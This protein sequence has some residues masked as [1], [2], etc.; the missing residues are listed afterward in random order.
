MNK[1]EPTGAASNVGPTTCAVLNH[2][3]GMSNVVLN[4]QPLTVTVPAVPMM[5]TD[6]V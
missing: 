1:N 3:A 4:V 6:V 2:G 5:L